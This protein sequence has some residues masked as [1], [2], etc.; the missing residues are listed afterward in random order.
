M[1]NALVY[2]ANIRYALFLARFLRTFNSV[3]KIIVNET[4][5]SSFV[6]GRKMDLDLVLWGFSG[7]NPD[8]LEF[9]SRTLEER[10]YVQFVCL[11]NFNCPNL[12][13]HLLLEGAA[14]AS[15]KTLDPK[16]LGLLCET[17]LAGAFPEIPE[18]LD[19][20]PANVT[21]RESEILFNVALGY[22]NYEI[23]KRFNLSIETVRSHLKA[24]NRKL[25]AKAREETV[26]QGFRYKVLY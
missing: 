19:Y 6:Q 13:E 24:V 17:L 5:A 14:A 21:E 26:A 10:P 2:D 4:P 15:Y 25:K 8:E 7:N 1:I 12:A 9:F 11:V 23:S 18:H 3:K 22:D 16:K 20:K